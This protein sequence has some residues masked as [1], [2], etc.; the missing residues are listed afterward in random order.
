MS[1]L[2]LAIQANDA[3]SIASSSPS[4]VYPAIYQYPPGGCFREDSRSRVVPRTMQVVQITIV[5]FTRTKV[6]FCAPVKPGSRN[7]VVERGQILS[8]FPP[9][10]FHEADESTTVVGILDT[11]PV[12]REM[13]WSLEAV[14]AVRGALYCSVYLDEEGVYQIVDLWGYGSLLVDRDTPIY[15]PAGWFGAAEVVH[16]GSAENDGCCRIR[17][18]VRCSVAHRKFRAVGT[19]NHFRL[20]K[21]TAGDD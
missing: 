6:V 13:P 3:G 10:S 16:I 20:R 2:R 5:L 9:T 21:S 15:S 7:T 4:G 19:F 11:I 14:Q 12:P 8:M 18:S 1:S 17:R